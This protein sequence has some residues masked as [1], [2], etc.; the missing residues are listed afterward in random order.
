M[1]LDP[2]RTS[3]SAWKR[4]A[5]WPGLPLEVGTGDQAWG[6]STATGRGARQ[7]TQAGERREGS[8][9]A[10]ASFFQKLATAE[11]PL[12][13]YEKYHGVEL[14]EGGVKAAL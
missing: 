10:F 13:H 3:T 6:T 1:S 11:P 4:P 14:T 9:Y 12:I 5:A 8:Y 2:A 7:R